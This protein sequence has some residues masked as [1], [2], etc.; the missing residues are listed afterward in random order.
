VQPGGAAADLA[1]EA[2]A[3]QQEQAQLQA[4]ANKLEAEQVALNKQIGRERG[5]QA[6]RWSAT[7]RRHEGS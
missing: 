2:K 1:R 3:D 4:S 6:R 5:A 7:A